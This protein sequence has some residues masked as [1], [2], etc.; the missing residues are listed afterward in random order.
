MQKPFSSPEN[1]INS[2]GEKRLE[3]VKTYNPKTVLQ[4]KIPGFQ[5]LLC[6]PGIVLYLFC[7]YFFVLRCNATAE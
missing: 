5:M 6:Y 7:F 1:S 2:E 4:K 3:K